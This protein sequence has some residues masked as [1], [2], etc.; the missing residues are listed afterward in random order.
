MNWGWGNTLCWKNTQMYLN[1][2]QRDYLQRENWPIPYFFRLV[3]NHL[4]RPIHT[5]NPLELEEAQ[6]QIKEYLEKG[7]IEPSASPCGVPILFV[8]KEDGGLQMVVNDW[9]LNKQTIK[10]CYPLPNVDDFFDQLVIWQV[11]KTFHLYNYHKDIIKF[12]IIKRVF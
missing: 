5:L 12:D 7:Q 2:Y 10:N 11:Q 8:K 6:R 9:A 3:G 1:L 4:F